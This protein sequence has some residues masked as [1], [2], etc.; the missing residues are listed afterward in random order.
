MESDS[1][2]VIDRVVVHTDDIVTALEANVRRDAGAV[3]RI[4]PP[5][6]GRIRARLHLDGQEADYDDPRP[7]HVAPEL[8]VADVPAFPTPDDTDEQLREAGEYSVERHRDAHAE[9]VDDWRRTVATSV[10][11][12]TTID[13]VE[14]SHEVSVV[15]LG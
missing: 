13:T 4:T 6:S 2:T 7:I 1:P 15:T 10:L 8:L 11:E 9:A 5:F 14:G 12:S 3:L